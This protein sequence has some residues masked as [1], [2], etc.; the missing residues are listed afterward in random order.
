MPCAAPRPEQIV[1]LDEGLRRR[2]AASL[3]R[4][5]ALAPRGLDQL[6]DLALEEDAGLGDVTSRAIFPAAPSFAGRRSRPARTWCSAGM[7]VAARVFARVDPEAPGNAVARDGT[8]SPGPG[9]FSGSPARRY[10]SSRPSGRLSISCSGFRHRDPD[11][12]ASPTPSPAPASA[13]WTPGRRR[14]AGA[15]W[16]NTPCAA[17]AEHNHRASLGEHVL[18]KDNHI[19]AAGLPRPRRSRC[20][21]A[22]APHVG[23]DRGRGEDAGRG[24]SACRARADVILLDN[25][26]PAPDPGQAVAII[27]GRGGRSRSRVAFA[28]KPC[29]T[30]LCRGVDVISVGALTHSAPAADLSLTVQSRLMAMAIIGRTAL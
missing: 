7:E 25:M 26:T 6:I 14:R 3:E 18:I 16:R 27:A 1:T 24:R 15:P 23:E 21:R 9:W 8:G 20:A 13:S 17:A 4:M 22:E 28:W 5:F 12:G 2:A 19:A 10:L 29:A 11:R 30:L